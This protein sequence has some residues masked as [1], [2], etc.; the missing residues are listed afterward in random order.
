MNIDINQLQQSLCHSF[1]TNINVMQRGGRLLV[2][3]PFQFSDGDQYSIYLEELPGG[4][5]KITDCGMTMMHLSYENEIDKFREG[6]RARIF[7]QILTEMDLKEDDGEFYLETYP[8]RLSSSIFQFGQALT[9][10]HDLNFL[11]KARVESTFYDDLYDT[12]TQIVGHDRVT[13]DYI[14]PGI[15]DADDYPIDY[16]I[17]T[18]G[19]PLFVFGVPNRDKARL[20]TIVLLHLIQEDV[21]FNS[22]IVFADQKTMPRGDLARLTNAADEMIASI[23]AREDIS[24]KVMKRAA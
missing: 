7:E 23:D 12:L 24:R 15:R 5:L 17:D 22:L 10:I 9:R 21:R 4:G 13:K 6:T 11:N 16:K 1:C 8:D 19:D 20:A 2:R 3:T 14:Q 18:S